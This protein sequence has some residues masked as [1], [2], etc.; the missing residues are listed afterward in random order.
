MN[1][2]IPVIVLIVVFGAMALQLVRTLRGDGYGL[3]PPPRSHWG[4]VDLKNPYRSLV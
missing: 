1:Q 3:R 2:I 4:E